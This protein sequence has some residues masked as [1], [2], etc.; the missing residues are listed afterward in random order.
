VCNLFSLAN[1][2][3]N[4]LSHYVA[5]SKCNPFNHANSLSDPNV[6]VLGISK[7]RNQ[8]GKRAQTLTEIINSK[9]NP[10]NQDDNSKRNPHSQG[11]NNSLSVPALGLSKPRTQPN[12]RAQMLT[13]IINSKCNPHSKLQHNAYVRNQPRKHVLIQTALLRKEI[14]SRSTI[15]L[16]INL[17]NTLYLKKIFNLITIINY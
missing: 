16:T 10:F 6:P 11:N 8:P 17:I 9:Y 13:E 7:P 12:K 3:H 5:N 1:S 15:T 14:E 2:K 4:P